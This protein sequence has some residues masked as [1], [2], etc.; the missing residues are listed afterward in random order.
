MSEEFY[1]RLLIFFILNAM[2]KIIRF[3]KPKNE[4]KREKILIKKYF[5]VRFLSK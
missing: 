4:R 3:T 2:R 5:N 1:F